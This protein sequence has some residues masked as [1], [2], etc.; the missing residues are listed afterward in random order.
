MGRLRSGGLGLAAA[1]LFTS[2]ISG[3]G[4]HSTGGV[5]PFAASVTISPATSTSVQL[6]ATFIFTATARNSSGSS[7]G[8]TFTFASSDTS[9]VSFA[10]G[11]VACAGHWDAGFTT[12]TP[13][14]TGVALITA[15]ALGATSPPT[16]VFVHP[17]IDNVKVSGVLLNGLPIQ[18]PCLSQGQSM[19]VEA[20]AYSQGSDITA[21]V[22]PF[23]WSASNSSVVKLTPLVNNTGNPVYPFATNQATAT[24][25]TPGLTQISATAGGGISSNT[26]YQPQY[27]NAQGVTSP[28]L[29]FFETCP[30]QNIT[31][32]LGPAGLIQTGQT[33]FVTSKGGPALTANAILT[34]VMGNN[35]LLDSGTPVTLSKIPLVWS[36]SHPSVVAPA[37]GC[38]ESCALS[39]PLPG[40]GSVTA[41]CSPPTCNLGFPTIPVALSSPAALAACAQFFQ[42]LSCQQFIPL[43]VYSS[44]PAQPTVP[45]LPPVAAA[46]TG[47]V[48]GAP[49]GSSVLA[50]SLGCKSVH[51]LDC[52]T[53]IYQVPTSKSVAG[54][55]T[56][57]PFSPNSILFDLNGDKAYIGSQFGAVSVTPSNIGSTTNPFA[58]LGNLTGNVLATSSNGG[59]AI[60]SNSNQ[61]F[62]AN[63]TASSSSSVAA[64]NILNA[65]A[66][67]FSP[68]GLRAFI[69]GFD[70]NGIPNLYVYSTQQALQTVPLPA[71]TT[72][73]SITSSTNGAFTY[74]V[75]SSVGGTGPAVT[76]YNNCVH[77]VTSPQLIADTFALTAPP[78]S[79]K[80]LPDGLHFIALET[81]GTFDYITATIPVV[82]AA[83]PTQPA[84]SLCPMTVAHSRRNIPLNQGALHPLDFFTS[85]DGTL[86]YVLATDR[87]SVLV[88]NFA[89]GG[90]TGI[91]LTGNATPLS[92]AM[93]PDAG[94]IV[95]NGSDG[96]L[97]EVSTALGGADM[98]P[99]TSFPNLPNYL[100]PF[101]T[102][103][104]VQCT[105][106]LMASK[107]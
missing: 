64:L 96:M 29:D 28:L 86:L 1:I 61:V 83:T 99:P 105:L 11:G 31:L 66:A 30:I 89:T 18:E 62:V 72:V 57:L 70:G 39:T 101:C 26:F 49:S 40:A 41:S 54:N 84:T 56:P 10:P 13:G 98:S 20:H 42:L 5:S 43:P 48:T 7:S 65:S 82:T 15:A 32:E 34:D 103:A 47:V 92:G 44:P 68:D 76:V 102:Y 23:T 45:P 80:A 19:T 37:T 104:P 53:Y 88:Y 91:E 71:G 78:I 36:A 14:A 22:G 100:N 46:I 4:G 95:I 52:T 25:S 107:P 50:S 8:V 63:T 97:H 74:V 79:F 77:D 33:S 6:G 2:S 67:A 75:Q 81:N 24:A 93:T 85:A 51:P 106:N 59:I 35:S 94:T 27:T 69:F 12:C 21:S 38:M 73:N 60:F 9:I 55:A 87:A 17:P 3:C 58:S 16:Y 90:V